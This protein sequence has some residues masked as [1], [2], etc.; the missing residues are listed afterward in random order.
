MKFQN[1]AFTILLIFI[2][3]FVGSVIYNQCFFHDGNI[4]YSKYE[5]ADGYF[6]INPGGRFRVNVARCADEKYNISVKTWLV[7]YVDSENPADVTERILLSTNDTVVL[8]GCLDFEGFER[9]IPLE[10]E[11]DRYKIE[12][13]VTYEHSWLFFQPKIETIELETDWFFVVKGSINGNGAPL[14]Q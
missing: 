11:P 2:A 1:I 13:K 12:T 14:L 3:L 5:L 4:R 9:T 7:R 8:K 10:T 6:T